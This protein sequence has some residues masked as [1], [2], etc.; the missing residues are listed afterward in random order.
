MVE[1]QWRQAGDVLVTN[2]M[3]PG[4]KLVQRRVHVNRVPEHDDVDHQT[5]SAELIFLALAVALAQLSALAMEHR[6]SELMA[7]LA[8]VELHQYSPPICAVFDV[9]KQVKRLH[10]TSHLLQRTSE[11]RWPVLGLQ[12]AD[13]T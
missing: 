9:P 8:A 3:P 12:R 4:A 2:V 1:A 11:P 10:Q 13:Q 7:S 5:E 6:A